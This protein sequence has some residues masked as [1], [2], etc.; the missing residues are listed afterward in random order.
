MSLKSTLVLAL[1]FFL[2]L[3][4]VIAI[5][6]TRNTFKYLIPNEADINLETSAYKSANLDKLATAEQSGPQPTMDPA[7]IKSQETKGW[8]MAALFFAVLGVLL[9][10]VLVEVYAPHLLPSDKR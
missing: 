1:W 2:C 7:Y 10:P 9:F 5:E 4:S 8:G 6:N 3:S